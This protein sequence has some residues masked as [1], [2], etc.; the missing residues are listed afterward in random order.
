MAVAQHPSPYAPARSTV[1]D[2]RGIP[3]SVQQSPACTENLDLLLHIR[4]LRR[5]HPWLSSERY[6]T[7]PSDYLSSSLTACGFEDGSSETQSNS[8]ADSVVLSQIVDV[9]SLLIDAF[10]DIPGPSPQ[11]H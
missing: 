4:R 2:S 3:T 5:P 6:L 7:L 8:L 10:A 1:G 9:H 11:N